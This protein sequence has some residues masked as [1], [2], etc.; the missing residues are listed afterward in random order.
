MLLGGTEEK[1][2][3]G[4]NYVTLSLPPKNHVGNTGA[5]SKLVPP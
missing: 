1:K 2:K 5:F 4:L 3:G